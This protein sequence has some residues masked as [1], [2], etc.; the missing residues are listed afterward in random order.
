MPEALGRHED[1]GLTY[2]GI[3]SRLSPVFKIGN[4]WCSHDPLEIKKKHFQNS[5]EML[6]MMFCFLDY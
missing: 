6:E 4:G 2:S 5:L 1:K 3:Q